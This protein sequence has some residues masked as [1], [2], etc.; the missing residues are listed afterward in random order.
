MLD[1]EGQKTVEILN[2]IK[3]K[4]QRDTKGLI[5]FD[6]SP[7]KISNDQVVVQEAKSKAQAAPAKV[8]KRKGTVKAVSN[9]P[10]PSKARRIS[11]ELKGKTKELPSVSKIRTSMPPEPPCSNVVFVQ[12]G[13]LAPKK[14]TNQQLQFPLFSDLLVRRR[15]TEPVP[16]ASSS[17]QADFVADFDHDE[18]GPVSKIAK[19]KA[20][21]SQQRSRRPSSQRPGTLPSPETLAFQNATIRESE[22]ST[23]EKETETAEPLQGPETTSHDD[24]EA[25][26]ARELVADGQAEEEEDPGL[27]K[28][29]NASTK[30]RTPAKTFRIPLPASPKD[31]SIIAT[32]DSDAG[33]STQELEHRI[34]LLQ[35]IAAPEPVAP[36]PQASSQASCQSVDLIEASDDDDDLFESTPQAKVQPRKRQRK[37]MGEGETSKRVK[38]SLDYVTEDKENVQSSS[39]TSSRQIAPQF[40]LVTTGLEV[41]ERKKF[42]KFQKIYRFPGLCRLSRLLLFLSHRF[43]LV[44]TVRDN[45]DASVTHV[46]A[47]CK[48]RF[49]AERTL[50]YL[51]AV[52][53]GKMV[54]SFQWV[55]DCLDQTSLLDLNE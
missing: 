10:P 3:T 15:A 42:D 24:T 13:K 41:N 29:F 26:V 19:A 14:P 51:Q 18:P 25:V 50:K 36:R 27:T 40:V 48:D 4:L 52:A 16:A 8:S 12:L 1:D 37:S 53:K 33:I 31:T 46:L 32:E 6:D 34:E 43:L 2:A 45:V 38:K 7:A 9:P 35:R 23:E 21:K 20:A 55:E 44:Y 39:N 47:G 54:I 5:K 11:F 17:S 30:G 22:E 49:K 28:L